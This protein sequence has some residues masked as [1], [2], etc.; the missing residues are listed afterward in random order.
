MQ[1]RY[2]AAFAALLVVP[3]PQARGLHI[4]DHY[5]P[6]NRE[7]PKRTATTAII[8]HTTE[9]PT[10]GSLQKV[11]QNGEA[12]YLVDT[13]GRVYRIIDR[14]RVAY[15]CGRSMWNATTDMDRFTVGIE[16]V[17]YHHRDINAAQYAALKELIAQIQSVY[18]IPDERVLTHSMVAYGTPNRWHPKSHRGRKRCGMLFATKSVRERLGLTRGPLHDPDVRGGRLIVADA[19]LADVLYGDVRSQVTAKEHFTAE[20]RHVIARGRSAW[21]IA[22]DAYNNAGTVY[23]FPD[24]SRK[25]GDQIQDWTKLPA[26]TRVA[27]QGET[28]DNLPEGVK[29]LGRD[30]ATAWEL[31]GDES[32]ATHTVYFLP[33]GQIR[34]GDALSDAE[35]RSLPAGTRLLV[36]YTNGGRITTTRSAFQI[37]GSRWNLSTTY[38]LLPDA[39]LVDGSSIDERGIPQGT[40]VFLAQ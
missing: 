22:R 16:V 30:G 26:G 4:T 17:G 37:G 38:Y 31:A 7:R 29:V 23:L 34:T 6:R 25:R 10:A 14:D 40:V 21:D 1:F 18:R 39:S 24:G 19:Y 28:R 20:D 13:A 2:L 9:G 15:H 5:S 27:M 8:L 12:H 3:A 11:H 33:G 35:L 32:R 36:G